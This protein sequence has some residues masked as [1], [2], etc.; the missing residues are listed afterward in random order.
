MRVE[1]IALV[2]LITGSLYVDMIETL[3]EYMSKDTHI[4]VLF[5]S[6]VTNKR[7]VLSQYLGGIEKNES[8]YITK[9]EATSMSYGVKYTP[10]LNKNTG[11][12][13]CYITIY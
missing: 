3:K 1:I 6:P 2:H 7:F 12:L 8:G 4:F 9:A 10:E 5:F 11:A 13:V